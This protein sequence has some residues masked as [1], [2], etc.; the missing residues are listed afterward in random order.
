VLGAGVPLL[1]TLA[2]SAPGRGE[3]SGADIE[4]CLRRN[5]TVR[6]SVRVPDAAIIGL[7]LDEWIELLPGGDS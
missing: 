3:L 1:P 2:V 6:P 7:L 4:D 5:A